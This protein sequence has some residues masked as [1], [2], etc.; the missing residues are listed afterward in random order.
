MNMNG[1]PT[2]SAQP[3]AAVPE[4]S[5]DLS[6]WARLGVLIKD[7]F[8]QRPFVSWL[9]VLAVALV[10]YLRVVDPLIDWAAETRQRAETLARSLAGLEAIAQREE[11]RLKKLESD[12][13]R[14]QKL[15]ATL[16]AAKPEKAQTKLA[17]DARKLAETQG[18]KVI[19]SLIL[20]TKPQ[21][22]L[23]RV[24]LRLR[25]DGTYEQVRGFLAAFAK[26]PDFMAPASFSIAPSPDGAG[27]L[28]L[29]C[30]VV[31]LLRRRP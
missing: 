16:P 26:T 11:A 22:A 30:E 29:E 13:Q 14:L 7:N 21:G 3:E 28:R 15:A 10:L 9:I 24:A 27:R 2:Q 23:Q 20:A 4:Q 8:E 25:A 5:V 6:L 19:N 18:L 31:T 12:Y 17:A 1:A